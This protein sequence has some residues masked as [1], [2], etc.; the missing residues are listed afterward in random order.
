MIVD[1]SVLMSVYKKE[2]VEYLKAAIDSVLSQTVPPKDFVLVCDGPLNDSLEDVIAHYAKT[3]PGLFNVY[4]L[5]YNVGL[6]KA[7]NNGIL[8][9]KSEVIAR[10]DSDD[11]CAPDRMEKQLRAMEKT[12]ADIV[13]ANVIEFVG[14]INHTG[15]VRQ[16]PETQEEILAYVKKRTPFNHPTV[17]YR[18]RAVVE[19]GLYEDYRYFED[20]HLW[21]VMLKQ[22]VTG[23]NIQEN[24][25]YMRGGEAMYKRRGGLA[26]IGSIFRFQNSLRKLEYIGMVSF[27]VNGI[28]RSLVSL[29]PTGLRKFL[30]EKVLRK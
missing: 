19:A 22:G 21:A 16:V 2:K 9:C 26:Y 5:P 25:V 7:L 29:F 8:Q 3:A 20:Y 6:A 1:Y 14:D 18:K 17:M 28:S 23:Y 13:G 15:G 12:G 30:Y 10:M 24:L 4:R 11:I 27:L